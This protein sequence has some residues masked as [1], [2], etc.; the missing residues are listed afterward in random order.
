MKNGPARFEFYLDK[1]EELLLQAGQQPDAGLWLYQNNARTPLFMLEGLARLYSRLHDR[2][3]FEKVETQA[4]L[5]EDALGAI[6]YYDGFAKEFALDNSM[7]AKVTEFARKRAS[8]KTADLNRLLVDRKWLGPKAKRIAK[9]RKRLRRVDWLGDKDE[10]AAIAAYYQRSI[11]GI[12]KFASKFE[13]GFTN[14]ESQVHELRR[15]L[16]WLSIYPQAL[17]GA[18]QLTDSASGLPELTKYLIAE[19][20]NSPY[21]KMPPPGNCRWLL[22]LERDRFYALSWM[23]AELGKLKDS[24]LRIDLLK[25]AGAAPATD[26]KDA[27]AILDQ[28]SLICRTYFGEGSLDDLVK[29]IR[30]SVETR[31]NAA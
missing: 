30:R 31:A 22:M 19:I 24:G 26:A 17:Q 5:V 12:D 28:S 4:K 16:R 8:Q 15:K 14:L 25:E 2:K 11:D 20:V 10:I 3:T 23:I 27:S 13:G 6:D 18:V 7:P 21:N 1:L 29:S 9:I